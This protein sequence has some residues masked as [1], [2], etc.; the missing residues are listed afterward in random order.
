[1]DPSE[2]RPPAQIETRFIMPKY[3]GVRVHKGTPE[4]R[5]Q[6]GGVSYRE[7]G[8]AT[9][10]DAYLAR[11]AHLDRLRGAERG[12]TYTGGSQTVG[13]LR[14][15]WL[16]L[17]TAGDS[18]IAGYNRTWHRGIAP[19]FGT[20]KVGEVS[21]ADVRDWVASMLKSGIA[22][23][24]VSKRLGQ[25]R[26]ILEVGVREFGLSENPTA[27]VSL[28]APRRGQRPTTDPRKRWRV[29][30]R[31]EV[32]R[33]AEAIDFRF[34]AWIY[35]G[36]YLGLRPG[37]IAGLGI[38]SIDLDAR[39]LRVERAVRDV[40]DDEGEMVGV[41][42]V[43][44]L[45]VDGAWRT[46]SFGPTVAAAIARHLDEVGVADDGRLF[47]FSGNNSRGGLVQT[48][49]GSFRGVWRRAIADS[50]I[51]P[52]RAYDLRHTAAT[53]AVEAGVPI[54]RVASMLGDKVETV[55]RNYV[56][57]VEGTHSDAAAIEGFR[58]LE[59]VV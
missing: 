30:D 10:R 25:L 38:D 9:Q 24:T 3:P 31:D 54:S 52:L 32:D 45:K 12:R 29:L 36:A 15:R 2:E 59:A 23:S 20:S 47:Y 4:Y 44:E 58:H 53:L 55:V 46:V 42:L 51:D 17:Q 18:T 7:T 21:E 28:P 11:N 14:D 39:T 6:Y 41:E 8:F 34:R 27:N 16:R 26:S 13:D 1:L 50:G 33:L 22:R 56:H 19:R 43:D 37:E 48:R 35:I 57:A 40:Y 5:F 49:G